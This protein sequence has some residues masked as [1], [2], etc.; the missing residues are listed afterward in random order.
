PQSGFWVSAAA[1]AATVLII[2]LGQR[3]LSGECTDGEDCAMLE[4]AQ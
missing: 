2:A 3:T 1:G 4:P